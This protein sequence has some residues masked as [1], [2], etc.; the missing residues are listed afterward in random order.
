MHFLSFF[1]FLQIFVRISSHFSIV[2]CIFGPT[3]WHRLA[4]F[5]SKFSKS[6]A[7]NRCY[8]CHFSSLVIIFRL[9]SNL[10]IVIWS[11]GIRASHTFYG[12]S[13]GFVIHELQHVTVWRRHVDFGGFFVRFGKLEGKPAES[14][15]GILIFL[16][17]YVFSVFIDNFVSN[18]SHL[19]IVFCIFGPTACYRLALFCP[20]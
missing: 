15:L 11:Y 19:P 8:E 12:F 5:L 6:R 14:P 17:Y 20:I 9:K 2:I 13:I 4:D 10:P 3:A 7:V 18:S 16:H 1:L